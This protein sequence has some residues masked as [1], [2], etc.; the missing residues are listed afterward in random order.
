MDY[1]AT[2]SATWPGLTE[3]RDG[4]TLRRAT[5]AGNRVSAAT[6]EAPDAGPRAAEAAM[7]AMGQSPLF[8]IRP[9]E[10]DLDAALAA[11]GY[12][13]EDPSAL[14]GASAAELRAEGVERGVIRCDAPLARMAEIWAEDGI[15]PARL[16]VMERVTGPKLY[17]L[18]RDGDRPCGAA[19]VAAAGGAAMIHALTIAPFARRKGLGARVTRAAAAWALGAGAD[20]LALAV[21][22]DNAPA[23]ALYRG[24]GF[25]EVARYHYRRAPG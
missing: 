19:F 4:W 2:L 17:L 3:R 5:G 12:A 25:A 22:D 14:L 18:A 1:F 16:A 11:M 8:M 6:R 10:D 21:R 15:G 7:R 20:T 9:G 23:R 13:V 24:L